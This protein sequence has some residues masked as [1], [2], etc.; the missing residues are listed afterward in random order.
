MD[1]PANAGVLERGEEGGRSSDMDAARGITEAILEHASA[2]DSS[3]DP[4]ETG[5]PSFRSGGLGYI[6]DD[7]LRPW[8]RNSQIRATR[9]RNDVVALSDEACTHG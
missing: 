7:P 4:N 2:I 5:C 9:D 6:A 3:V 8:L 1:D